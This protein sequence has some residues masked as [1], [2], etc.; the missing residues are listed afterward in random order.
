MAS[1]AFALPM[2]SK[3]MEVGPQFLEE[4]TGAKS[5]EHSSHSKSAGIDRL[6]VYRQHT[7]HEMI[8]VYMEGDDIEGAMAN[9]AN[10]N[11]EFHKWF[12]GKIEELTGHHPRG[13]SSAA[14]AELLVDWHKEKGH[15]RS[16]HA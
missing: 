4:L 10:G 12:G 8:V 7:P 9:I 15:S 11:T 1:I 2:S 13:H 14:P 16:G 5:G 3:A 6:K